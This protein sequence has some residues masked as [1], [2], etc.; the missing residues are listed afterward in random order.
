MNRIPNIA[1]AVALGLLSAPALAQE[2]I[3]VVKNSKGQ[4]AIERAGVRV[5]PTRGTEVRKGDR[6]ITGPDSHATIT[7]RRAAPVSVGPENDVALDRYAAED[8]PLVKR[9]AP[10]IL[11]GLASFLAVNR[12]R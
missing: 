2:V 12:Q 8:I 6:L 4:V 11:Q 5:S 7:M 9:A 3:G 1:V 10:A